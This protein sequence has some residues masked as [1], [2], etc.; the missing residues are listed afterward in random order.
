MKPTCR[1]IRHLRPHRVSRTARAV[2]SVGGAEP[3]RSHGGF[4]PAPLEPRN[5]KIS[6][7]SS[8]ENSRD[9][10][11]VKSPE[12]LRKRHW[13]QC[14]TFTPRVETAVITGSLW[15]R[16]ASSGSSS[17]KPFRACPYWFLPQIF[18]GS[19]VAST[20]PAFIAT[21]QSNPSASPC[22]RWQPWTL[23][24][25]RRS[26]MRSMS[27][28]N[29]FERGVDPGRRSSR[30]NQIRDRE[31]NEQ[32]SPSFCFIPPGKLACRTIPDG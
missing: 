12:S 20:L 30:I 29:C 22:R 27:S 3:V 8:A 6:P 10:Q 18:L 1:P 31:I 5:P 28:Q 19:P 16:R 15:P 14:G 23:M 17:M 9:R 11:P 7:R 4:L 13:I 25:W 21:S 26:L 32:Q 2:P 24:S